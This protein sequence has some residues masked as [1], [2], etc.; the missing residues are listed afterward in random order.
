MIKHEI[1][2]LVEYFTILLFLLFSQ[3]IKI[4]KKNPLRSISN[5]SKYYITLNCIVQGR[6]DHPI[7]S[8]KKRF[9]YTTIAFSCTQKVSSSKKKVVRI[10]RSYFSSD[11]WLVNSRPLVTRTKIKAS[12]K[13]NAGRE[14][15]FYSIVIN[16]LGI[17]FQFV[18]IYGPP[19]WFNRAWYS[20]KFE[21]SRVVFNFR[22]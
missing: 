6:T 18:K 13:L 2:F 10:V 20:K 4:L 22:S 21:I 11:N 14:K 12:N 7:N 5:Q 8:E 3:Y 19:S 9:L 17:V 16:D 1:K 15:N